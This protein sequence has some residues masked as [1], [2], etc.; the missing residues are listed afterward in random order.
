ME[1]CINE[2]FKNNLTIHYIFNSGKPAVPK[3]SISLIRTAGSRL[4]V[5]LKWS[6]PD[7]NGVEIT[8]YTIYMKD[9]VPQSDWTK[10]D[11]IIDPSSRLEYTVTKNIEY[12][13][14]Y[15]FI[16][17]AWNEY[18]ESVKDDR[19][20]NTVNTTADIPYTSGM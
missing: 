16:V 7:D 4:S 17:T 2:P 15:K 11:G 14:T 10:I 13:K 19:S 5:S 18:G 3:L 6:K 12:G 8:K 1:C 9:V 20:A